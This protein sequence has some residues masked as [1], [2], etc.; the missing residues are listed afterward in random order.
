MYPLLNVTSTK[1]NGHLFVTSADHL[2]LG[3]YNL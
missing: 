3:A 1:E 2:G